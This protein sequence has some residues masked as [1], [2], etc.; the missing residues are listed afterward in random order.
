MPAAPPLRAVQPRVEEPG[1]PAPAPV[2]DREAVEEPLRAGDLVC[3][4]CGSGNV[5]TRRYCR[6]CGA[7]L[8]DAP[9]VPRPPWWRRLFARRPRRTPLAGERPSRRQWQRPRFVLP[10]LLLV[11]LGAAGYAFRG[12][13]GRAVEA[14]R[15]RTSKTEQVH[16]TKV[17]ASSARGQHPAALAVDGTT[18]K[19]WAPARPG[20]AEGEYL[21]A[22]FAAPMRLLDV[23]VHPGASPVAEKFLTQA[24]PGGLV[25]TVTAADG[26]TTVR[27]LRLADVPG[28]QRFHLPVSDA[29][30]VRLAVHG[31]YGERPDRHLAVAEVEF[32]KRR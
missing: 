3:G 11:A 25:V 9:V 30:R 23:V 18:D 32:F 12:E 29:V 6:R 31:A 1:R 10:L 27:T 24:R 21:E 7:S 20:A 4:Q 16:A 5:P 17:T 22:T 13:A 26:R 8:A 2:R 19:Y 15:D 28:P 14:V